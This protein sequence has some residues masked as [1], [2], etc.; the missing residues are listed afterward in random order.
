MDKISF[1]IF[2]S[3]HSLTI[4]E[5]I[6]SGANTKRAGRAIPVIVGIAATVDISK[7]TRTRDTKDFKFYPIFLNTKNPYQ[8][9]S[10]FIHIFLKRITTTT[11][12]YF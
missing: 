1:H 11:Y 9:E 2:I 4:Y 8:I 7:P 3:T 6:E 5:H 10:Y 12:H